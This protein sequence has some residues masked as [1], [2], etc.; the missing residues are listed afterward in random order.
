MVCTHP[1]AASNDWVATVI[2]QT[3]WPRPAS[4]Y[5]TW[6][7]SD[8]S[9]RLPQNFR[10]DDKYHRPSAQYLRKEGIYGLFFPEKPEKEAC[11]LISNVRV[12]PMVERMISGRLPE[13]EIA[14]KINSRLGTFLTSAA[15]ERYHHYY[16]NVELLRVEDWA[17]LYESN[18]QAKEEAL[19][20]AQV[21]P[22]LALHKL[23][24]QQN[25]DSKSMLRIV[26]EG[27]FFDFLQWKAQPLSPERTKAMTASARTMVM[28]DEQLASADSALK[29]SLKAFEAFKMSHGHT[30]IQDMNSLAPA[31]NFS[32]SGAKLLDVAPKD[33]EDSP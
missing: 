31:G 13:K 1:N 24:F 4:D 30:K 5:L 6:L 29:D 18:Y 17:I 8:T 16:W 12:R 33:D 23:G 32:G 26:Q 9:S 10:T 2:E 20:V 11:D 22:S 21:G 19:A 15:I 25:I 27:M 14:K 7:R 28:V 3:G